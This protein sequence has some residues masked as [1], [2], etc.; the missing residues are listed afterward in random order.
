MDSGIVFEAHNSL[1]TNARAQLAWPTS[2]ELDGM[3]A[4]LR[5]GPTSTHLSLI[6]VNAALADFP[7]FRR[8]LHGGPVQEIR[9]PAALRATAS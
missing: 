7:V 1:Q 3:S 8:L 2:S 6:L 5:R 4:R 9:E